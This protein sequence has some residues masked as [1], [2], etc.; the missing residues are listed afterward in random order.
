[1]HF[2]YVEVV[3]KSPFE[4]ISRGTPETTI[5]RKIGPS[6]NFEVHE[7]RK[8]HAPT[9]INDEVRLSTREGG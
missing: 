2:E 5:H 9:D 1:M 6:S 8:K 3:I 4:T 7:A